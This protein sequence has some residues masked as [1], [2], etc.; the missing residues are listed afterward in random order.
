MNDTQTS[1]TDSNPDL[2]MFEWS[3]KGW[4]TT[5]ADGYRLDYSVGLMVASHPD[6][7]S[8]CLIAIVGPLSITIPWFSQRGA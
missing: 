5:R 6:M 4:N 1:P 8:R 7:Q 2:I 3:K